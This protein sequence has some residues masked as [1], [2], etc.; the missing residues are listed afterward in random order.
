MNSNFKNNFVHHSVVF[1]GIPIWVSIGHS[2]V[3]IH[4]S[5]VVFQAS[6]IFFIVNLLGFTLINGLS[7]ERKF[8]YH[9]RYIF[10]I[11]WAG[12]TVVATCLLES[13]YV[14]NLFWSPKPLAQ[15]LTAASYG[16]VWFCRNKMLWM[17]GSWTTWITLTWVS[18]QCRLLNPTSRCR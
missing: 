5:P 2:W 17:H 1:I 6:Y 18:Q 16:K 4:K 12:C 3:Y 13:S 7:K 8:T 9:F 10:H 11:A 14:C 15:P